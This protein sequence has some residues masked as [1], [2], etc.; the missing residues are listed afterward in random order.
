[1]VQGK[2]G[3]LKR[4]RG[5]DLQQADPVQAELLRDEG[6]ERLMILS[7]SF[8]GRTQAVVWTGDPDSVQQGGQPTTSKSCHAGHFRG[9]SLFVRR[10]FIRPVPRSLSRPM[11]RVFTACS[12]L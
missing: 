9:Q 1:M 3:N 4:M 2:S 10:F 5:L 11:A 8:I 6:I 7:R 12:N